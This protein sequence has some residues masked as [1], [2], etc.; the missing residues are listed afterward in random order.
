M[1]SLLDAKV[2]LRKAIISFASLFVLP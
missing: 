2:S 1:V